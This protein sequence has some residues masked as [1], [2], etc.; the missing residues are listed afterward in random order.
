MQ[1]K[2]LVRMFS[3][4]MLLGLLQHAHAALTIEIAEGVDGA[5]LIAVILLLVETVQADDIPS[6]A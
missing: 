6:V 5:L 3:A 1:L 2:K 4:V